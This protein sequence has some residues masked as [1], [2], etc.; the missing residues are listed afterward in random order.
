ME[1]WNQERFDEIIGNPT[2]FSHDIHTLSTQGVLRGLHFQKAP[3]SQ[4]KLVRCIV[5]EIFDVIVDIRSNSPTFLSWFG[6]NLNEKNNNQIWIPEGFAHGFL[7]LTKTAEV[8]YKITNNWSVESERAIRWN[9]HQI[10]INWPK[11]AGNPILSEK[12]S[13]A[14][15]LKDLDEQDLF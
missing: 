7:T 15:L 12:D 11:S 4:G 3:E 10:S 1:S 2:I 8:I 13:N 5:G 14:P 6:V 9:D